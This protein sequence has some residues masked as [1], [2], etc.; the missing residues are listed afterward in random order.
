M[1]SQCHDSRPPLPTIPTY[2]NHHNSHPYFDLHT[3]CKVLVVHLH[4]DGCCWFPSSYV[5]RTTPRRLPGVRVSSLVIDDVGSCVPQDPHNLLTHWNKHSEKMSWDQKISWSQK[6][7][8]T[9]GCW[10]QGSHMFAL[11]S[12]F[13][14]F[15][16]FSPSR[17]VSVCVVRR[18]E[19]VTKRTRIHFQFQ[20]HCH[21]H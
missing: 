19:E 14:P 1:D 9:F 18:A 21:H 11:V 7:S 20:F 4:H 13:S 8:V 12:M 2:L 6:M 5:C 16:P 3:V 15:S 17:L 10:I